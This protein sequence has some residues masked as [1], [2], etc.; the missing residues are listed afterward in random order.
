MCDA[1]NKLFGFCFAC[2]QISI[3]YLLKEIWFYSSWLCVAERGLKEALHIQFAPSEWELLKF[4]ANLAFLVHASCK[5]HKLPVF[6]F[7]LFTA[8]MHAVVFGNVTAIIQRMYA[9]RSQYQTK[10]RDLK[11][12]ITLHQVSEIL[13]Q[14]RRA[15]SPVLPSNNEKPSN[16][17]H[18]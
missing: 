13:V 3:L 18:K 4:Y 17:T 9:R 1:H 6:F 2:E 12:F 11:D 15:F 5:S 8:L 16:V 14:S 7:S 10:W